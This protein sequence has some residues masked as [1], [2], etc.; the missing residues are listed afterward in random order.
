MDDKTSPIKPKTKNGICEMPGCKRH[1]DYPFERAG[2]LVCLECAK[3]YD[4]RY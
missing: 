4:K 3:K 1:M 2:K